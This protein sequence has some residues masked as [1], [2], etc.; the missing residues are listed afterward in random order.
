LFTG[1]PKLSED[2]PVRAGSPEDYR[3]KAAALLKRA[4]ES[5]SEEV[6]ISCLN[7]AAHWHRL[8]EQA[9]NPSW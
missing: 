4:E 2:R 6:R 7:M 8:A 5:S 9:E 1:L 3:A